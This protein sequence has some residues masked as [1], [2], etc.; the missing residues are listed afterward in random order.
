[1]TDISGLQADFY[2]LYK[3]KQDRILGNSKRIIN[4][5]AKDLLQKKLIPKY[6]EAYLRDPAM[7]A[8][9]AANHAKNAVKSFVC[10]HCG[11]EVPT[12]EMLKQ[13]LKIHWNK[14][15]RKENENPESKVRLYY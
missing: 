14:R 8:A 6:T 13:H 2:S 1:M 10:T 7:L 12:K 9:A 15:D 4:Q 11:L 5:A 3:A